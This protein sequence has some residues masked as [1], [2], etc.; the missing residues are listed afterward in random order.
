MARLQNTLIYSRTAYSGDKEFKTAVEKTYNNP[1]VTSI[2]T[3]IE[4]LQ[5]I[6]PSYTIIPIYTFKHSNVIRIEKS[7]TCIFDSAL[8][9]F[10]A[11]KSE[12]QLDK[13]IEEIN[14]ILNFYL[15]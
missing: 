10:A 1:N 8:N 5:E 6:Y 14:L 11:Y 15:D 12:L 4:L 2:E 13:K 3:H 9:G 7:I